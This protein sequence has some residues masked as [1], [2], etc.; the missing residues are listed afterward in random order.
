MRWIGFTQ[1]RCAP[2]DGRTLRRRS[3]AG[4][5]SQRLPGVLTMIRDPSSWHQ[6][7]AGAFFPRTYGKTPYRNP[8]GVIERQLWLTHQAGYF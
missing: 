1:E 7:G 2:A 8:R 5:G 4:F 6:S 3:M